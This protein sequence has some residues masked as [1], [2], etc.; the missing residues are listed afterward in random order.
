MLGGGGVGSSAAMYRDGGDGTWL[1]AMGGPDAMWG[2]EVLTGG[3][4]WKWRA[5]S[6]KMFGS[7]PLVDKG[8]LYVGGE[9]GYLYALKLP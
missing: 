4:R 2:L 5:P 8:R 3:V 1:A 7:S 6:G 9:D